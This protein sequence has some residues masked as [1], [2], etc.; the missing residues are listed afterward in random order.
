[1]S[2]VEHVSAVSR[3]FVR[4]MATTNDLQN[5]RKGKRQTLKE[6]MRVRNKFE[7]VMEKA[8]KEERSNKREQEREIL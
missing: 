5:L 3:A 7:L 1:M 4:S 6:M 2:C 8:R